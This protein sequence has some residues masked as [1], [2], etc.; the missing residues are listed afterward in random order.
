MPREMKIGHCSESLQLGVDLGGL[1]RVASRHQATVRST[2]SGMS[3]LFTTRLAS[4]CRSHDAH[5]A[6][7]ASREIGEEALALR[8]FADAAHGTGS[9]FEYPEQWRATAQAWSAAKVALE[10]GPAVRPVA[11]FY[12]TADF[13]QSPG[14][15]VLEDLHHCYP[16][17][18]RVADVDIV[19]DE[20]VA[21]GALDGVRALLWLDA[22]PV[23]DAALAALEGWVRDG[24]V[25]VYAAPGAPCDPSRARSPVALS[26][27][28]VAALVPC[29]AG[30]RYRHAGPPRLRVAPGEESSRL[31][32][33]AGWLGR[34]NGAFAW[35][36]E[37][38]DAVVPARWTD[39]EA[40]LVLPRPS[41]EGLTLTLHLFAPEAVLPVE[42]RID[43]GG[44]V[45][46]VVPV[47][48][49]GSQTV[50]LSM[51]GLGDVDAVR[52]TIA[53]GTYRPRLEGGAADLR[54]LGVL[55]RD[56]DLATRARPQAPDFAFTA[57]AEARA[58]VRVDAGGDG[59]IVLGAEPV[60]VGQGWVLPGDGTP[61]SGAAWLLSWLAGEVPGL[62]PAPV[63]RDERGHAFVTTFETGAL[64]HNPDP[65]HPIRCRLVGRGEPHEQELAPLQTL[66]VEC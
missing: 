33:G 27:E 56:V 28:L 41:G 14:L 16:W 13:A 3:E 54:D 60:P 42:V 61:L 49:A 48:A 4:L 47:D 29:R 32:L 8:V 55:V 5:F 53:S 34:E 23:D 58:D 37:V 52:L 64:V 59:R 18:R 1:V 22:A 35:P 7:E 2:Q 24:G 9:Y 50:S 31:F 30:P 21:E 20:Q 45:V 62:T 12:P 63:W 25:L 66:W 51:D 10:A 65:L 40:W 39:G 17:L 43:E 19:D 38:P 26:D 44:E 11:C 6:T 46:R 15:G 57:H 36:P